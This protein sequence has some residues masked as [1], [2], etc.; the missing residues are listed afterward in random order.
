MTVQCS[1]KA[2][3][4]VKAV[5]SGQWSPIGDS[6]AAV[7]S[8]GLVTGNPVYSTCHRKWCWSAGTGCNLRLLSVAITK[9]VTDMKPGSV[10]YVKMNRF[11]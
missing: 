10:P 5:W 1:N 9:H 4:T 6:L 8:F 3:N 2:S 11:L 7:E